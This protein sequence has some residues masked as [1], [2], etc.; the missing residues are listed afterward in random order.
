VSHSYWQRGNSATGWPKRCLHRAFAW[1]VL[2]LLDADEALKSSARSAFRLLRFAL[3]PV[4]HRRE[5]CVTGR[6]R[7]GARQTVLTIVR[8]PYE[9]PLGAAPASS[10]RALLILAPSSLSC[11]T[12]GH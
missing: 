7:S 12:S 11:A 4:S 5:V 6:V 10:R 9:A 1:A 3:T 8:V 2:R